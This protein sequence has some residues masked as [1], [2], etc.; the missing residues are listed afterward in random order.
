[1][2]VIVEDAYDRDQT[3]KIIQKPKQ[4]T[5]DNDVI[6]I[7][8]ILI[9]C[10]PKR[11]SGVSATDEEKEY[12]HQTC[13]KVYASLK[14]FGFSD[15]VVADSGNGYH[16]LYKVFA[17]PDQKDIISA[18]LQVLDMWFSD[19]H[20][21]IDTAVFNPARITKLYGTTARKGSNSTNR[22]HRLS[23]II[24]EGSGEMTSMELVEQIA[25]DLPKP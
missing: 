16:L 8:W 3:C 10:D 5:S 11:I 23:R 4:T 19:E 1:M 18:F 7:R 6:G 15:P 22:P 21:D 12:A 14:R 20:V 24:N 2:N 25:N 13:R 9:D 17:R